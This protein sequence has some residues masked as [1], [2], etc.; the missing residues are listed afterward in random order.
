MAEFQI[1][2]SENGKVQGPFSSGQLKKLAAQGKFQPEHLVSANGGASWHPATQVSG[3]EFDSPVASPQST[4]PPMPPQP[5]EDGPD[6]QSVVQLSVSKR[7]LIL[8]GSI[9]G[10]LCV[11]VGIGVFL[12]AGGSDEPT[13]GGGRTSI[14]G[15]EQFD[16]LLSEL[17]RQLE[18]AD[19]EKKRLDPIGSFPLF[20]GADY[21]DSRTRQYRN[22][23]RAQQ[24][25]LAF[26]DDKKDYIRDDDMP[27]IAKK[28]RARSDLEHPKY[29][30]AYE[31]Q[32][33]LFYLSGGQAGRARFHNG[34]YML[35]RITA[36]AVDET[37]DF[38][39]DDLPLDAEERRQK[40]RHRELCE[41]YIPKFRRIVK[42]AEDSQLDVSVR[43]RCRA[44]LNNR[45][46]DR[47]VYVATW[48]KKSTL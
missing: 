13:S 36:I 46:P 18:A 21:K 16:P 14:P 22:T 40:R 43:R 45:I 28:L 11:G 26:V 8:A 30:D 31:W 41:I 35:R 44:L 34:R 12:M 4:P 47:L 5:S 25:F 33:E 32:L 3:L 19:R 48:S 27:L 39:S 23:V 1:K 17:E 38:S 10:L 42:A 29:G 2:T 20:Y 6:E 37:V 15:F 9:F 7:T 24:S